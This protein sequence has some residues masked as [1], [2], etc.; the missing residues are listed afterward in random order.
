MMPSR[1]LDCVHPAD[2]DSPLPVYTGCVLDMSTSMSE[3]DYPPTRLLAAIAAIKALVLEK[4]QK[5]PHDK[6][7]IV[8]FA[9]DGFPICPMTS[10]QQDGSIIRS[11]SGLST[12]GATDFVVGLKLFRKMLDCEAPSR[13]TRQGWFRKPTSGSQAISEGP[14][15]PFVAHCV[16]LSDGGHS[17]TKRVPIRVCQELR[18]S[19][20][21]IDCIGI[22]GSPDRV[23]EKCL[24]AM[25]S[26]GPDGQPRYRFIGDSAS[27]IQEFRRVASIQVCE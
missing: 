4:K 13:P 17:G 20:V 14:V 24:K 10:V 18:E 11:L 6:V 5:R 15:E 16:F 7:G 2:A 23:D 19:N 8:G 3:K 25:A 21:L 27:L 22:G 1:S 12:H 9:R 26:V